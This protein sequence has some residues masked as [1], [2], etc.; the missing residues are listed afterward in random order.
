M[1]GGLILSILNMLFW[2]LSFLYF[3]SYLARKT[4]PERILSD[5][6]DEVDKL[7]AEID[8]A[9]DRDSS[10][11]EDRIKSLRTL[12]DEADRRIASYSREVERRSSEER[13]YAELGRY[14]ARAATPSPTQNMAPTSA[15]SAAPEPSL[16]T[17]TPPASVA[18]HASVSE[19]RAKPR[20]LL[21]ASS[22]PEGAQNDSDVSSAAAKGRENS[23]AEEGRQNSRVG[24]GGKSE[25]GPR[26]FRSAA[27]VEPKAASFAER[28][29][30]LSRAG[31]S[32]DLIAK[33]LG[34]TVAEVDLAIALAGRLDERYADDTGN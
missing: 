23:G 17:V 5:F 30:E 14:R 10:L 28:V 18:A 1:N 27:P 19:T 31:F 32:A 24:E 4:G 22:L 3:R 33:R 26:F 21:G 15:P 2:A 29:A 7:I 13:A 25:S 16:S 6:R 20:S 34:A 8:S 9:T 11:I 12:L